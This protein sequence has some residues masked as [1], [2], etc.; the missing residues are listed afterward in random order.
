MRRYIFSEMIY[1][2]TCVLTTGAWAQSNG[3]LEKLK[4]LEGD[5]KGMKD[6]KPV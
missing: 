5:W 2:V 6:G 1:V 3:T 4:D